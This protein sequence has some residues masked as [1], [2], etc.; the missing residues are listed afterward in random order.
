MTPTM[1]FAFALVLIVL[2]TSAHAQALPARPADRA[3]D[4]GLPPEV[5]T[6]APNIKLD[7]LQYVIPGAAPDSAVDYPQLLALQEALRDVARADLA[8][9]KAKFAVRG[10]FALTPNEPAKFKMQV[11]GNA[12][13]EDARL[14]QFHHDASALTGFHSS[15]GTIYVTFDYAV[16]P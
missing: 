15:K 11:G 6:P 10:M 7:H 3:T 13:G 9:A 16:N 14:K 12:A 2:V 8:A 4:V 1:R 5:T